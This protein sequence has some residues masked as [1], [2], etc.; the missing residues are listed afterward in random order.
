MALSGKARRALLARAH[1][2]KARVTLRAGAINDAA[3]EHVRAALAAQPLLKVRIQ[4][5]DRNECDAAARTLAEQLGCELV[6]R[7]GRVVVLYRPDAQP[8]APAED[9]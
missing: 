4:T 2:L 5:D 7:I 6:R 1:A 3:V 8:D 9:E